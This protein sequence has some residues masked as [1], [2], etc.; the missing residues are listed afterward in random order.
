VREGLSLRLC[1]QIWQHRL[2]L[3]ALLINSKLL[4]RL[5]VLL[6]LS[7]SCFVRAAL[8]EPEA[9]QPSANEA[10]PSERSDPAP[11][12]PPL[13]AKLLAR[14]VEVEAARRAARAAALEDPKAWE[15]QR[16]Q[17]A[18]AH[19]AQLAALWGNIVDSIDGQARLRMH[20]ERMARL[21]RMLDLAEL[22]RDSALVK[23]IQS[24]IQRE[25]A[26][27]VQAM[28]QLQAAVG[29]R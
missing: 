16:A 8:G 6:A 28:Q 1:R 29:L 17:R 21:N 27:H 2:V 11:A 18:R 24:D 22:K 3:R 10:R 26:R 19:R 23:R 5:S 9:A 4:I 13:D 7:L 12:T 15:D 20:A 14:V 25:L